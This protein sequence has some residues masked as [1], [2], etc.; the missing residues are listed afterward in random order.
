[1]NLIQGNP[2]WPDCILLNFTSSFLRLQYL[3]M[4]FVKYD[5]TF[6][7]NKTSEKKAVKYLKMQ[8]SQ[9]TG[10]QRSVI[11]LTNYRTRVKA[12]NEP[13][14]NL[15]TVEFACC[16][17]VNLPHGNTSIRSRFF[18]C[19]LPQQE[20]HMGIIIF[21]PCCCCLLSV[22][23]VDLPSTCFDGFQPKLGN[24]CNMGTLLC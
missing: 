23:V 19:R 10:E 5:K 8:D 9:F 17:E 12:L 15:L 13:P 11:A 6:F 3:F 4:R 18:L 7:K 22:D 1:M 21:V 16:F 20:R 14:I 2:I 24:R